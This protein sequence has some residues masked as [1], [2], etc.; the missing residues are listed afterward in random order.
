MNKEIFINLPVKDLNKTKNFF[1]KL[2]FGFNPQFTN[3]DAACMVISDNIFSMLITEKFF[4][5]F[6]SKEISNAGN[7]TEVIVSLSVESREKV[8][9]LVSDALNAGASTNVKPIEDTWMYVKSFQDLDGHIWE[10]FHMDMNKMPK[11]VHQ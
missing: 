6:T 2:G 11:D 5:Q 1:E 9:K 10:I 8:D 3:D 7:S 4:K